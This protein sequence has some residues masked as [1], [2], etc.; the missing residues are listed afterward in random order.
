MSDIYGVSIGI[1]IIGEDIPFPPKHIHIQIFF[2]KHCAK[3]NTF[4]AKFLAQAH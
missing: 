1:R 2:K 3:Q 4:L